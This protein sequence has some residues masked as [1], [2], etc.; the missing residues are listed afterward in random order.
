ME[1]RDSAKFRF[2]CALLRTV[3]RPVCVS[4]RWVSCSDLTLSN[5]SFK[6]GDASSV[7]WMLLGVSGEAAGTFMS[8]DRYAN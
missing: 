6:P 7:W 5:V 1:F 4:A 8:L 2:G 3:S